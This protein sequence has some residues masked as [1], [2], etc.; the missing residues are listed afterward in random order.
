MKKNLFKINPKS[1]LFV[2]IGMIIGYL[3]SANKINNET[4]E[5]IVKVIIPFI[6]VLLFLIAILLIAGLFMKK[7]K[8]EK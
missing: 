3:V 6:G 7:I 4:I 1:V 2:L 8:I 5:I